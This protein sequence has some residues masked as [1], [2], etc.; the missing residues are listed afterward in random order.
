MSRSSGSHASLSLAAVLVVG[1]DSQGAKTLSFAF[2]REGVRTHQAASVEE[3]IRRLPGM[4]V[5]AVIAH[6]D[7]PKGPDLATKLKIRPNSPPLLLVGSSSGRRA[8]MASGATEFLPRPAY[9]RDVVAMARLLA[10][11]AKAGVTKASLEPFAG[12]FYLL[13]A[14][15]SAK[16][17]AN[18]TITRGARKAELKLWEGAL[19]GITAGALT[20]L[21]A[22]RLLLLWSDGLLEVKSADGAGTP[23]APTEE[24]HAE[25]QAFLQEFFAATKGIAPGAVYEQ[26]LR[27]TAENEGKIP[28]EVGPL[29]RLF[30]GSRAIVDVCEEGPFGV[31]ESAK[32]VH[33]L[34]DLGVVKKLTK[35]RP[36]KDSRSAL[37][38]GDDWV[39]GGPTP[40]PQS[41]GLAAVPG[42]IGHEASGEIA[43]KPVPIVERPAIEKLPER[44]APISRATAEPKDRPLDWTIPSPKLSLAELNGPTTQPDVPRVTPA[45]TESVIPDSSKVIS[46]ELDSSRAVALGPSGPRSPTTRPTTLVSANVPPPA[47][48]VAA[49]P[50]V[51]AAAAPPVV[52]APAPPVVAAPPVAAAAVPT[53]LPA[54]PSGSTRTTQARPVDD[55]ASNAKGE[56]RRARKGMKSG[57]H[58]AVPP[59]AQRDVEG[60]TQTKAAPPPPAAAPPAVAPAPAPIAAAAIPDPVPVPIPVPVPPVVAPAPA[61]PPVVSQPEILAVPISSPIPVAVPV[62]AAV[63]APAPPAM[64]AGEIG[65]RIPAPA[66]STVAP[67]RSFE[68]KVEVGGVVGEAHK[69]AVAPVLDPWRPSSGGPP[70][71][72]WE[73]PGHAPPPAASP[74]AAAPAAAPMPAVPPKGP[75]P[76]GGVAS[77][78]R[79]NH[80]FDAIEEA[81]FAEENRFAE[82]EAPPAD[83]FRDL[84]DG[85]PQQVG[86][87]KKLFGTRPNAPAPLPAK[88]P[89]PGNNAARPTSAPPR[90]PSRPSSGKKRR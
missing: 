85:A 38:L 39:F 40:M 79:G 36:Q 4:K 33:R 43:V 57:R 15:S 32:L 35:A 16:R 74:V 68:G 6:L 59:P 5:D 55:S 83:D 24:L 1:D 80:H 54:A 89:A 22:Y 41:M 70:A 9:A 29:L 20:G 77:A 65:V 21:A 53:P 3:A 58:D 7:G 52:A 64:V 42:A 2:E 31:L 60:T 62:P 48:A 18:V 11:P 28:K 14:M 81:F 78:I 27:K 8:A 82:A 73:R 75:T 87:W 25:G 26:D 50:P 17:S 10:A 76:S 90:G 71:S 84:D 19:H 46:G 72:G 45:A 69:A 49:A 37:A 86:F 63:P 51:V 56:I 30:D 66:E 44:P 67:A 13:R 88:R 47:A 34:V 61:K 23:V 12:T